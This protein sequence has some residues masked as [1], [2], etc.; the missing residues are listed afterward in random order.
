M[1]QSPLARPAGSPGLDLKWSLT[2]R[3]VAVAVFCF[4]IAAGLALFG[5]WREVRRANEH[6]ADIVVRQLQL[7]VFR[8]Q[9]NIELSARFPDWD[10]VTDRVQS[11]GQC[12][13]YSRRRRQRRTI[14]LYRLQRRHWCAGLVHRP[15]DQP[16][17]GRTEIARQIS[18]RDKAYGTLVVTTETGAILAA[19]WKDVSKLLGL[20][21]LLVAAICL[22]QYIAIGRALRPTQHILAGLNSLARGDL[23]CRLPSF[24]LVEFR[25]ISEVFNTL[26]ASLDRTTRER[27]ALA[28]RL[29]DGQEQERQ[30]L[31]RELHDELA[32]NLSAMSALATSIKV[33]AETECPALAP[34]A[35]RLSQVSQGIVK[36]LR[37]T[38]QTLRPP[39]IDDLGLAASLAALVR[40]QE[41]LSEGKLKVALEIDG[42]L[43]A[44]PPTSA[45]HV[46]RIVQE[47][48]TNI[49]K[50]AHAHHAHITLGPRS[51]RVTTGAQRWLAL[52]IEDDGS[53]AVENDCD[54]A[55]GG[56]G[57]IGM[58]ERA[59]AL[60]GQLDIARNGDRGFRLKAMIPFEAVPSPRTMNRKA[61]RVLLVDDHAVVREGYRTL[62]A[63]HEGVSVVAEAANAASAYQLYKA[64][65][66]DVVIM[67]ISMPGRGGIDAIEHI[68]RFDPQARILVFTMHGGAVYALQAFRA[69]ARGYV[70]KSSPPDLLVSA[71]RDVAEGRIAICPETSEALALDRVRGEKT[72]ACPGGDAPFAWQGQ[73]RIRCCSR[74][75]DPMLRSL[76][77][78]QDEEIISFAGG[79]PALDLFP[80]R[81]FQH[82][83]GPRD[84]TGV[85]GCARARP[86]RGSAQALRLAPWRHGTVCRQSQVIWPVRLTAGVLTW[87][88]ALPGPSRTTWS[89]WIAPRTSALSRSSGRP[90]RGWWA[91]TRA[92]PISMSWSDL[93]QRYRPKLLYT[94]P[95]FH[96]PSGRT[97]SLE[98]RREVLNLAGAL[99]HCHPGGRPG[100]SPLHLGCA[101]RPHCMRWT[102]TA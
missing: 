20:T 45:S 48:L 89:S 32:Q 69:G 35:R 87:S 79:M 15:R 47:G 34:E 41:R 84:R 25:R 4:L 58:R 8:I 49:G 63:K 100:H 67:D 71:V 21:A 3:V 99:P 98:T 54:A 9:S 33:T 101:R 66:P 51:D 38:L 27:T 2:L 11:A 65:Q 1:A 102:L 72:G 18:Y 16:L 36:S 10:P 17:A 92:A 37:T 42:A 19:I 6:V 30:R 22:L 50:H 73:G 64:T 75:V 26:A 29:V 39:E 59:M 70:T 46:Y 12:V 14:E 74:T 61:I 93:F 7:Q 83:P 96:N 94:N 5:T 88:R 31:A 57:L 55:N 43:E 97:L 53:G 80:V 60:G 90:A 68:R 28:A 77:Q 62:L 82:R 78:G 81:A 24:R 44:L 13:K 86:N 76:V 95:T 40:D 91:G 56:L 52:T 23:S 85:P